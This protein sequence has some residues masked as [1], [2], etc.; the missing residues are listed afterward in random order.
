MKTIWKY[1]L[2]IQ[3]EANELEV[4]LGGRALFVAVQE[5]VLCVWFEVD[6]EMPPETRELGVIGTGH[7]FS[8]DRAPTYI[9]SVLMPPFVWHVYE[10]TKIK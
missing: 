6:P 7:V 2:D 10:L 8:A 1:P 5:G 4:P 3:N 9:G